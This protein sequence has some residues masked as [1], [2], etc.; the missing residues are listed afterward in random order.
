M[1][2]ADWIIF[3]G[4]FCHNEEFSQVFSLRSKI[5]LPVMEDEFII[6]CLLGLLKLGVMLY[7]FFD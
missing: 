3:Q 6:L 7:M 5:H 2:S 4:F 1:L